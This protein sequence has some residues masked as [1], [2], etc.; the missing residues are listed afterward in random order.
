VGP[1]VRTPKRSFVRAAYPLIAVLLFAS[2]G[3]AQAASRSATLEA[4]HKLENPRNS[5]KPGRHGELG[6]YQFRAS[7]WKMHTAVPFQ[8]ALD[9]GTSDA[10]ALKHYEWIKRGLEAAR[11]PATPYY[12]AL[13]WNS[14]LNAAIT[15]RSPRIAHDYAQRAANLAT[16]L[17]VDH[18]QLLASLGTNN[19]A[20]GAQ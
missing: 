13:A 5:P 16:A 4:I 8:H 18:S 12:I 15:G 20:V 6:A 1:A 2:I 3:G 19:S 14:G 17:D 11:V 7:T 9:R 10:I